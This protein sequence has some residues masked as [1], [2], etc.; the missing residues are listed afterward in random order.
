MVPRS[1][2]LPSS[3]IFTAMSTD[4]NNCLPIRKAEGRY[5]LKF[6]YYGN[7]EI[8]CMRF[9][10]IS[11]ISFSPFSLL[12]IRG[13]PQIPLPVSFGKEPGRLVMVEYAIF[14]LDSFLEFGCA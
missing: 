14:D 3:N 2:D 10:T 9:L 11:S 6:H 4:N 1:L 12:A 7:S 5:I 13:S 8:I